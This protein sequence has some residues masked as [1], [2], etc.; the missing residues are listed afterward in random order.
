L[1]VKYQN[2]SA[3]LEPSSENLKNDWQIQ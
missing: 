3:N 2:I 1:L